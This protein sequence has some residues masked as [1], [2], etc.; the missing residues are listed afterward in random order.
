MT[1][2]LSAPPSH[3]AAV[4]TRARIW[5]GGGPCGHPELL[6][7]YKGKPDTD[8]A[9]AKAAAPTDVYAN[10]QP[11]PATTSHACSWQRA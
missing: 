6:A 10:R 5:R 11:H 8:H 9:P 1:T 3:G 4:S 2:Q 7:L